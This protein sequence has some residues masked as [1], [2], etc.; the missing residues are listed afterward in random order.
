MKEI[1]C[2]FCGKTVPNGTAR[3][4]VIAGPN[5][6]ICRSCAETCLG[7]FASYDPEWRDRQIARLANGGCSAKTETIYV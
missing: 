4:H 6:F 2:S 7:V 5:V 3:G 1:T